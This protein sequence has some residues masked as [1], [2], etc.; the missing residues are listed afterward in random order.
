MKFKLNWVLKIILIVIFT[1]ITLFL[2]FWCF[3]FINIAKNKLEAVKKII[4]FSYFNEYSNQSSK[5]IFL[6]V[7]FWLLS[8]LAF[9]IFLFYK[10]IGKFLN[11]KLKIKRNVSKWLLNENTNE[12]NK[13]YKKYI[14]TDLSDSSSWVLKFTKNKRKWLNIKHN[15]LDR[16][17]LVIGGTGSGKTQRVL[18]PNILFNINLDERHRPNFVINDPKKEIR[19]FLGK[20]LE[21]QGYKLYW[22]DFENAENSFK[23]N[24]LSH[25]Y[26][27]LEEGKSK[28]NKRYLYLAYKKYIELLE[29]LKWDGVGDSFWSESGKNILV[30]IGKTL[31][32]LKYHFDLID[33][34]NFNFI[35]IN[36]FLNSINFCGSDIES[37]FKSPIYN[38]ISSKKD[39]DDDFLAVYDSFISINSSPMN[40]IGSM[41]STAQLAVSFFVKNEFIKN[42]TSDSMSFDLV[43]IFNS[44]DK[45]AIFIHY[46]DQNPSTHNL[47]S[48]LINEMYESGI[49]KAKENLIEKGYE[50]LER[51][52]L[53]ILE[54]FGNLPR[55]PEFENKI[56]I[57]RSRNILFCVVLQDKNQLKKYNTKNNNKVDEIILGNLQFIYF[58]NSSDEEIKKYIV[59]KLGTFEKEKYSYSLNDK[60]SSSNLSYQEKTLLSVADLS[61]KPPDEIIILLEGF[62][63]ILI[64]SNLTYQY[65][66]SDNYVGKVEE[67]SINNKMYRF[68][69]EAFREKFGAGDIKKIQ[70]RKEEFKRSKELKEQVKINMEIRKKKDKNC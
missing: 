14:N 39:I 21:E 36:S 20:R 64:K 17:S 13:D 66:E 46:P 42:L 16:N 34:E 33:R 18:L 44:N 47:V 57:N 19:T 25:I 2:Y 58:L 40:T 52:L 1:L 22:I 12:I 29:N 30:I 35:T 41:L 24:P 23:W 62:A 43:K 69:L 45:F 56:S 49:N 60:N 8:I 6:V 68:N 55:I 54:E 26:D 11:K 59:N 15:L 9:S 4:D 38:I 53:F 32:L 31:M 63:P 51:K 10:E 48:N 70:E 3:Y 67:T 50:R 7:G 65:F 27:L 37:L 61:Q 5:T 28:N